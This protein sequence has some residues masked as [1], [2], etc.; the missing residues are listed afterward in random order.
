MDP[1]M[2]AFR[3]E[4]K[5]RLRGYTGPPGEK[6]SLALAKYIVVGTFARAVQSGDAVEAINWGADQ[7]QRIYG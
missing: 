1:K 3:E 2:T 6:A 4:P 7:W 5:C